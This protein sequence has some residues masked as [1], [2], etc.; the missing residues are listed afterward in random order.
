MIFNLIKVCFVYYL[1]VL[2]RFY[3]AVLKCF[4]I[5]FLSKFLVTTTTSTTPSNVDIQ[6]MPLSKKN[7][8]T[9]TTVIIIISL[10]VGFAVLF[11]VVCIM[12]R[13]KSKRGFPNNNRFFGK[14]A[15]VELVH[16]NIDDNATAKNVGARRVKYSS[17]RLSSCQTEK[18]Y[19][20][21]LFPTDPKWEV[22]FE[23]IEFR[24][25]IGEGAFGRVMLANIH[26]LPETKEASLAAVKMLKG[27]T[28][29]GL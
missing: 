9:K 15:N 18:E 1:N 12:W 27:K 4:F 6:S 16:L 14:D 25:Y 19:I 3:Q 23:S 24:G 5:V 10:S 11:A 20:S 28:N 21:N 26:E 8:T 7:P 17:S 29:Q 22:D 13:R 2:K